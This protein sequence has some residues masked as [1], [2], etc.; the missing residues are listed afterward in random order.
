MSLQDDDP[1]TIELPRALELIAEH[2]A[3]NRAIKGV[4][5]KRESRVREGRYGPYVTNGKKN[6]KVPKDRQPQDLTLEDCKELIAAAPQR[7]ARGRKR[8]AGAARRQRNKSAAR[9]T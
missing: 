5:G 2:A 9:D 6:A 3:A 8:T 1:F 4:P 7:R